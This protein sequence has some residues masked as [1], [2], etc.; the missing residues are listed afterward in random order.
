MIGV[1]GG[2]AAGSDQGPAPAAAASNSQQQQDVITWDFTWSSPGAAQRENYLRYADKL[3]AASGGRLVLRRHE[4]GSVVPGYTELQGVEAGTLDIAASWIGAYPS[5][6]GLG[7][8]FLGSAAGVLGPW[9][10]LSWG[11]APEMDELIEA[12][13]GDTGVMLLPN[14]GSIPEQWAL[15]RE[16]I[17]LQRPEDFSG[18]R[19]R[20]GGFFA[21]I[22]TELGASGQD[23]AQT[24]LFSALERGVLDCAD[25][26]P[27]FYNWDR[28]FHEI[29]PEWM[30]PGIHQQ[31]SAGRGIFINQESWDALPQDLQVALDGTIKGAAW[32]LTWK[33]WR[34][35]VDIW[36]TI[37]ASGQV[38]IHVLPDD[39]QQW[40]RDTIIW[41]FNEEVKGDPVAT[42]LWES[43]KAF[44]KK[45][46]RYADEILKM[47]YETYLVEGGMDD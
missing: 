30:T 18:L 13:M 16:G 25:V 1:V 46:K 23:I 40:I 26:G 8:F 34:D 31:G 17:I 36:E 43:Q 35:N 24:E 15:C 5:Y 22:I 19:Y 45:W 33:N 38:N 14:S 12:V 6:L 3:E 10:S 42:A 27:A 20:A 32:D 39:T 9:G 21:Q 7:A 41:F 2:G 47:D 44:D 28:F 4:A 11:T 29:A 37:L